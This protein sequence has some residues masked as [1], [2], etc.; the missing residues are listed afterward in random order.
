MRIETV[1]D[2]Q[3]WNQTLLRLPAP[4]LLQS[5]QWGAFKSR[6]GWEPSHWLFRDE[7][8]A[9]Q[10]AALILQRQLP[11][12]PLKVLYVPK[13]PTLDYAAHPL[14]DAVLG[15]L[16]LLARR[17]RALFIKI[18]PDVPADSTL[19]ERLEER[20][21]RPSAEQIQFRNTMLIDLR[22]DKETLL[23][24]MKSKW[25]YNVR[26]AGRRGVQVRQGGSDD[27]PL[28]YDMYRETSLRDGFVIRPP[29][30]YQDAWGSFIRAGLAQPFIAEFEGEPLAMVMI[31]CFG[32][33][34]WYLYGA[35]R[36]LHRNKMP[37]HR[38]QWEAMRWA[39]SQGCLVYDLWGGP[40]EPDESDPMW[41]VYRFKQ[42]FGAELVRHVG[43]YDYPVSR[44]G[45][46][47]YTRLMPWVLA[48]LRRLYW[49]RAEQ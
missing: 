21:W 20:G 26:L 39:K 31:F 29:D 38:L 36:D 23:M 41:G 17:R 48:Q 10:A 43:A 44:L 45:H 24:N 11:Y 16:E 47:L 33:R 13:G 30:Y 25:R 7:A 5:W 18:D 14:L 1:D 4:H 9:P 22:P 40:D 2:P 46:Q 28:L 37:N 35:S 3:G 49:R 6:H 42:G 32:E 12:T 8:G 15:H 34:A 27:L 19:A